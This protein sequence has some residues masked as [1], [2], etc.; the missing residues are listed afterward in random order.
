MTNVDDMSL[1]DLHDDLLSETI[2]S[3][4][5]RD[6]TNEEVED[7]TLLAFEQSQELK[8]LE[9]REAQGLWN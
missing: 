1:I 8:E 9:E 5:D 4:N 2:V 7:L 3:T 6:Y